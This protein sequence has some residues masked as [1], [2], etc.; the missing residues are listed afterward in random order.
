MENERVY[1]DDKLLEGTYY[2]EDGSIKEEARICI[3]N[4]GE[5]QFANINAPS[6]FQQVFTDI[7]QYNC[8]LQP[9]LSVEL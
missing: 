7:N 3:K 6:Q 9:L 5:I 8:E 1:R 4:N 2:N